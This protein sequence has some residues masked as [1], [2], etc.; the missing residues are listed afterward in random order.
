MQEVIEVK[1]DKESADALRAMKLAWEEAE[2]GRAAKAK[3]SRL[4]Y[5]S[6]HVLKVC[7]S[8]LP[9]ILCCLSILL[10][11]LLSVKPKVSHPA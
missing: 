5:L 10:S 3:Q 4:N 6:T 2:P 7:R 11:V 8:I 9:L 1:K